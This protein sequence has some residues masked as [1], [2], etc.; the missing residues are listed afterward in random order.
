MDGKVFNGE[1]ELL[2]Y[3]TFPLYPTGD[4]LFSLIHV[5]HGSFK[6]EVN[7]PSAPFVAFLVA[8]NVVLEVS[9]STSSLQTYMNTTQS[10]ASASVEYGP[11]SANV[12]ASYSS[13]STSS[14]C[15]TTASGCR[16]AQA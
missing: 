2:S 5:A 11:F 16:Y 4:S 14:S 13:S 8:C 10:S 15:Q 12:K 6:P 1:A 7:F 9:G 3:S